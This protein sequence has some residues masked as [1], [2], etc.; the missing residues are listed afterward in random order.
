[1]HQ[2]VRPLD[3]P[4]ARTARTARRANAAR[5]ARAAA[6]TLACTA[7]LTALAA[8]PFSFWE[9][10]TDYS[11]GLSGIPDLDQQRFGLPPAG[12]PGGMYCGPT[13]AVDL[14]TFMADNGY[15]ALLPGQLNLDWQAPANFAA[16]TANIF[17]MG[18][19]MGCSPTGGTGLVGF[20]N[21]LRAAITAHQQPIT[22]SGFAAYGSYSPHLNQIAA[23]GLNNG[24]MAMAYGYYQVTGFVYGNVPV[25]NRAGGHFVTVSGA[26]R[27]GNSGFLWVRDPANEQPPAYATQSPFADGLYQVDTGWVLVL[28]PPMAPVFRWVSRINPGPPAPPALGSTLRIIDAVVYAKPR[29][30]LGRAPGGG[31]VVIRPAVNWMDGGFVTAADLVC[32]PLTFGDGVV[33]MASAPDLNGAVVIAANQDGIAGA[34]GG[35]IQL[36]DA[37]TG[38]VTVV[39]DVPGAE[40]ICVGPDRG[41]YVLS[42]GTTLTRLELPSG[43]EE[44]QPDGGAPPAPI[45]TVLAHPAQALCWNP[46]ASRVDAVSF[47]GGRVMRISADLAEVAELEIPAAPLGPTGQATIRP[48]TGELVL[49]SQGH[50]ELVF[51]TTN[52]QGDGFSAPHV[53]TLP[54]IAAPESTEFLVDGHMIVAAGGSIHEFEPAPRGWAPVS[55]SSFASVGCQVM[56]LAVDEDGSNLVPGYHDTPE[57]NNIDPVDLLPGVP[58]VDPICLGD[59]NLDG[60]V[61]GGD[62]A[63]LLSGWGPAFGSPADFDGNAVIDGADLGF[64]LSRWGPCPGQ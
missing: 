52:A 3:A 15:P 42:G 23:T 16:G 24:L 21:G 18:S 27:V 11:Y 1:M 51:L 14:Y 55:G 20:V 59:L 41:V 44:A 9:S 50:A 12:N 53:E 29:N 10:P 8:P 45:T 34:R 35:N 5:A 39:A 6:A 62:L 4:T 54:G 32:Q 47:S 2:N 43:A 60:Q 36:V 33:D 26:R 28:Q 63:I 57:W 64:L 48:G 61:D 22:V 40:R 38:Q 49:V 19:L 31:L 58:L 46:A 56:R 30:V 25:V 17:T 13:T 7:T 37:E